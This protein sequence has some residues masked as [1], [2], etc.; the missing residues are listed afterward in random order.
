M[1]VSFRNRGCYSGGSLRRGLSGTTN[2]ATRNRNISKQTKL[3]HEVKQ[4]SIRTTSTNEKKVISLL[5][6]INETIFRDGRKDYKD[7]V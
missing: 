1:R 5:R 6:M 7:S 4:Q 3:R 2:Y